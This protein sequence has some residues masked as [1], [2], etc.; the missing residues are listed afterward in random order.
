MFDLQKSC[1][2]LL[3]NWI[4][5][6]NLRP[7]LIQCPITMVFSGLCKHYFKNIFF[8]SSRKNK[9]P[10]PPNFIPFPSFFCSLYQ[11]NTRSDFK[12]FHTFPAKSYSTWKSQL[13][14]HWKVTEDWSLW[15]VEKVPNS[16]GADQNFYL[17]LFHNPLILE[18]NPQKLSWPSAWT[19]EYQKHIRTSHSY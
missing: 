17:E 3:Q 6:Q 4:S 19:A 9:T 12:V 5:A 13:L 1:T 11:G 10:P 18:T 8:T 16:G 14:L 15:S 7:K 2:H